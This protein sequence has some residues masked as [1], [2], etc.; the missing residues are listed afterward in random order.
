MI[1]HP[2]FDFAGRHGR[3]HRHHGG[4][5]GPGG[6]FG[7]GGPGPFG[8]PFRG[9]F[10]GFGPRARRGDVRAGVLVLLA[11]APRNGY[12]LM[13]E[14]EQRSRGTWRPSPGSIYPALQ[15]LQEEGLVKETQ[16]AAG[17]VYELTAEGSK[18]VKEHAEELGTPWEPKE[19]FETNADLIVELRSLAGAVMQL[20]HHG[21]PSQ[22][23]EGK[24][25]LQQTRKALYRLLGESNDE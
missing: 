9:F 11:E 6:P 15:Q 16:A 22:L 14:L 25:L 17:R 1:H 18:Y 23:A 7:P 20:V 3:G 24:K 2:F 12:Q 10:R 21:S 4:P 19:G 13:Q 5:G 8:G